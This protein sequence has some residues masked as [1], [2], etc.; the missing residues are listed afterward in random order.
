MCQKSFANDFL[1]Q[2]CSLISFS[3]TI[4]SYFGYIVLNTVKIRPKSPTKSPFLVKSVLSKVTYNGLFSENCLQKKSVLSRNDCTSHVEYP[5]FVALWLNN[6]HA[7]G[8]SL[9]N[10]QCRDW[11]VYLTSLPYSLLY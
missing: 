8:G 9:I 4:M 7:C 1:T 3:R 11:Q 6:R 10:H 5:F 2:K